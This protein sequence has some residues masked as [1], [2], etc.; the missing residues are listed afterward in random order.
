MQ[1]LLATPSLKDNGGVAS[2]F[3]GV[4]PFLKERHDVCL[5]EIGATQGRDVLFHPVLDQIRFHRLLPG[6]GGYL[7]HLNPSLNLKS[8]L[9]DG[10]FILQA[11][12]A[13]LPVLVFFHGW[14]RD[15][16]KLVTRRLLWLF[17]M[18]FAR[19]D[20]FIV[21]AGDF[22]GVLRRWGITQP[23]HRL[24]TC[25]DEPLLAKFSLA[26]KERSIREAARLKILFLSRLEREKGVFETVAAVEALFR[27]DMPVELAI[28]GD[29]PVMAEL[30]RYLAER[31]LPADRFRLL[32]YVRGKD[33]AAAFAG[34]HVYCFPT[35]YG[36]GLPTSV[37]EAMAFAMPVLTCPAGG[38]ADFF[39]DGSMGYLADAGRPEDLPRL[40]G[41]LVEDREK[42][43]AMARYNHAHAMEHFMASRVAARLEEVYRSL[44]QP[45]G[46]GRR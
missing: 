41:L 11:K 37:L 24:T 40:L 38:I 10:L 22:A 35:R 20:A 13:G 28:A 9:R 4:M 26:E 17:R 7:V 3:N 45:A 14:R 36:E 25:V 12:R 8:F 31:K 6:K 42:V 5:H 30:R 23:I 39:Q 1:L 27:Q 33:K 21:L 44:L 32:G 19:A 16:E 46:N 29:G 15:F 34:H 18:T 43:L 2:F